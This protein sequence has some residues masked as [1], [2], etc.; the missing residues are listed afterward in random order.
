MIHVCDN[1]HGSI[2]LTWASETGWG[3]GGG[4]GGGVFFP[5]SAR[6]RMGVGG[7]GKKKDETERGEGKG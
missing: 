3:G 7:T 2:K 1:F 4:G 5:P 6:P